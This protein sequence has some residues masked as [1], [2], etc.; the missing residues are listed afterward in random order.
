MIMGMQKPKNDVLLKLE[1]FML[2]FYPMLRG[3]DSIVDKHI[4]VVCRS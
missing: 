2:S 3:R 1:R 4:D